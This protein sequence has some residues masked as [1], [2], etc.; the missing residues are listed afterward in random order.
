[1]RRAVIAM[2]TRNDRFLLPEN[3]I[4]FELLS[5]APDSMGQFLLLASPYLWLEAHLV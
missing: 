5:R 1:M 4:T 3:W 2:T